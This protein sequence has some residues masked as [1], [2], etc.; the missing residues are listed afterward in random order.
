MGYRYGEHKYGEGLYSR[1][2]DWWHTKDCLNDEWAEKVCAALGI[3]IVPPPASTLEPIACTPP[4]WEGETPETPPE[5]TPASQQ[6]VVKE[7]QRI[8]HL[9]R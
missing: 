4:T 8:W 7:R 5:W 6:A 3:E 9:T 1:W 2:P